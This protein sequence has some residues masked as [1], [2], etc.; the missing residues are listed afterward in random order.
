MTIAPNL[1]GLGDPSVLA[2]DRVL[3]AL[4]ADAER[5]LTSQEAARRLGEQGRNEL[6]G[7]PTLATWRRM[8]AQFQDPLVYLLLG[9][10]GISLGAWAIE[11]FAGWPLDAVVIAAIVLLNGVLGHV[12]QARA[13]DAVA[14]LARMT[15]VSSAVVRGGQALP[16]Q[17]PNWCRATCWSSAKATLSGPMPGFCR[18]RLCASSKRP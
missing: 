8:L 3:H 14:A 12:Q 13:A 1:G 18:P 17:A 15:A 4:D 2:I 10:I 6:R 5:G 9:A 16:F 11:G 7:A